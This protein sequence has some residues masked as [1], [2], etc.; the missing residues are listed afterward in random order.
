M[1][2]FIHT[3]LIGALLLCGTPARAGSGLAERQALKG[4][5]P[6]AVAAGLPPTGRLP[7]AQ[8]LRLAIGLPLRNREALT[9]LLQ[10]LYDPAS[11]LYHKYL[12]PEQFTARFGPEEKDYQALRR[13][14]Q[15]S[16]LTV[17]GTYP[18]RLVLDVTGAAGDI[19]KA[20]HVTLRVYRHPSEARD[21]YAPDVEPSVEASLPIAD[22]SG[23][24]NYVLPHPRIRKINPSI[25]GADTTP[26]SG[27]GSS[28][29]YLGYD[30]RDAYL[31]GVTLT[32]SGQTLGLLEF[33]GYYPSDIASIRNRGR[34]AGRA[35]A[36]RVA[37]RLQRRADRRDPAAA[38][39]KSRSTSNWRFA[40]RRGLPGSFVFE[41]GPSGL[42][43]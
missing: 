15:S 22:I 7:A 29:T 30:F 13:F 21:F 9:N 41:A 11:P 35:P 18:N 25:A 5:V 43:E 32:G 19:E 28:G 38:T 24:N 33:D 34:A 1:R 14:A 12:E 26:K 27:S 6:Q 37:G 23:L 17:S 3:I 36:N 2:N 20:F 40:W 39:R 8:P 42:R 16:G 31:P 10:Q 4:H